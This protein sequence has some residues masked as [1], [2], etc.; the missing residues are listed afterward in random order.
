M[1][2][3][4]PT[5]LTCLFAL[6]L[7]PV[8]AQ[9]GE[10]TSRPTSRPSEAATPRLVS[11]VEAAHGAA[12]WR[13][14]Q[15]IECGIKVV[16]GGATRLE[17]KLLYE[18]ARSRVR[19][20]LAQGGQLVFD[21]QRAW[22]GGGKEVPRARFHLLTWPYFLAA[23]FKLGDP[24]ARLEA[25]RAGTLDGQ[26][27]RLAKLTF[28][29]GTGDSPRDWYLLHVDPETRRLVAM[30]YTVTYG[31]SA[32]TQ[33]EQAEA[34]PHAIR[35][36]RFLEVEGV[37]LATHWTFHAWSAAAGLHGQLGEVSLESP[38]FVTPPAGAFARPD[39]AVEDA[40]PR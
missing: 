24:G 6:A 16:F 30:A 27:V 39:G 7:A 19:I 33:L 9:E 12:A 17:G 20:E 34:D 40:L 37:L 5:G 18:P 21:G 22:V 28:A 14:K 25:E 15:A 4:A 38:R 1:I 2:R 36:D 13:Q 8:S 31:A 11:D 3:P 26:P 23:P 10:P 35:Y 29:E 32:P